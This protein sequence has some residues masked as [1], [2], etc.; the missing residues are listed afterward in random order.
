[1]SNSG[2]HTRKPTMCLL[3]ARVCVWKSLLMVKLCTFFWEYV[4]IKSILSMPPYNCLLYSKP[5]NSLWEW[6]VNTRV[7]IYLIIANYLTYQVT[8]QLFV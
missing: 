6:P 3:E 4:G 8:K 1:M 7:Q 5:S 2:D